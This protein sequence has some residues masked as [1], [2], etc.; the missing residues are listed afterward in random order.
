MVDAYYHFSKD[1]DLFLLNKTYNLMPESHDIIRY[2][3][4]NQ[5]YLNM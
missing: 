2:L 3:S 5:Y 4:E 1:I